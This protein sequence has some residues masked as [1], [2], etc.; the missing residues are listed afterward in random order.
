MD[1]LINKIRSK[2]MTTKWCHNAYNGEIFSYQVSGDL[3]D[4]SR[5]TFLAY[6]DY[7]TTNFNSKKDAIEWAKTHGICN[8]CNSSRKANKAGK[9]IFCGTE[10]IFK[11]IKV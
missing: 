11:E 8:K 9:C 6:G 2:E 10:I 5:G 3:T 1:R 4:F 7:L